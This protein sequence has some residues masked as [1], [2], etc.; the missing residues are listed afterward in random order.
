MKAFAVVAL[1]GLAT[2]GNCPYADGRVECDSAFYKIK[3][4][5]KDKC[6]CQCK[7]S[8][9]DNACNDNEDF[10]K[11]S[12]KK[13]TGS[14]KG[15]NKAKKNECG[16]TACETPC[17]ELNTNAKALATEADYI[18]TPPSE[19][20][21]CAAAVGQNP[22]DFDLYAGYFADDA[23]GNAC[24]APPSDGANMLVSAALA[25]AAV[26]MF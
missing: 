14:G 18:Q 12:Y 24:P 25:I 23:E 10:Y 15:K 11:E 8:A 6:Q 2:A 4:K 3:D 7:W 13:Y 9:D 22:C 19:G 21:V 5:S 16:C 1:F 17:I 20:C 26:L